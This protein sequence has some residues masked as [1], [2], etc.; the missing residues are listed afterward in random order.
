MAASGGDD[1]AIAKII[2]VPAADSFPGRW[3]RMGPHSKKCRF[4]DLY[5]SYSVPAHV[6]G[7]CLMRRTMLAQH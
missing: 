3:D 6:A 1:A 4:A 2:V 7:C 5:L